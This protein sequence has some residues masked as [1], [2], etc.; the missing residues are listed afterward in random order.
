MMIR[1][2]RRGDIAGILALQRA[3]EHEGAMWGYQADAAADW[4]GRDLTWTWVA[5]GDAVGELLGYVHARVR[6]PAGECVF[7]PDSRV[8]EV[9]DLFVA[10]A[11]RSRGLGRDLVATLQGRAQS[12]GFTHLRVYSAAKR[13]DDVVRFYRACGFEP[14]YLE[15]VAPIGRDP[16]QIDRD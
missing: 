11:W 10:A 16:S 3:V 6:P 13:F 2:A 1:Q 9:A 4:N 5:D 7:D 14:W 8:L 15:M 12:E